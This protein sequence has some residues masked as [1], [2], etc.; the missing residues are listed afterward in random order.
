VIILRVAICRLCERDKKLVKAHIIAEA[1]FRRGRLG[2]EMLR[3]VSNAPETYPKRAPIGVY[4]QNIL[5]DECE[6]KF[7]N[8]DTYA[9]QVLTEPPCGN[10]HRHTDGSIVA[11]TIPEYDYAALKLFAVSVLW[12]AS[13][14]THA[15][16]ERVH[17]G[18]FEADAR[19]MILDA[20]AGPPEQLLAMIA[21]IEGVAGGVLFDPYWL[22]VEGVNFYMFYL[23]GNEGGGYQLYIKVDRR[24]P[25]ENPFG[26]F[27][28]RPHNPLTIIARR[29]QTSKELRLAGDIVKRKNNRLR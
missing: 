15:F 2:D 12:R 27:A 21:R 14:S 7:G 22:R 8:W 1:F 28:L 3:L 23:G 18:P 9:Q 13:V 25:P 16:F 29:S 19:Q 26:L 4:D 20:N 11:W 5:C 24:P 6:P 10:P 17:A